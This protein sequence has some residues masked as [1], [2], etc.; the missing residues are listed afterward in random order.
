MNMTIYAAERLT[1]EGYG[2]RIRLTLPRS[3]QRAFKGKEAMDWER[4]TWHLKNKD[5]PFGL[6]L[7]LGQGLLV[8]DKDGPQE[9]PFEGIESPMVSLTSKGQ[10]EFF[11][12]DGEVKNRIKA[13]S[14]D[15]DILANGIVCIPPSEMATGRIREW[16]SGILSIDKLPIFPVELLRKEPEVIQFPHRPMANPSVEAM[17]K[18]IDRVVAVEGKG[19]DRQTFRVAIKIVSVVSDFQQALAEILIW[20]KTN[21]IP[22]WSEKELEWKIKSALKYQHRR[23]A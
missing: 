1:A 5:P 22:P 7:E 3:K 11:R 8:K 12:V 23:E 6:A 14:T 20:N 9:G 19:G 4:L 15:V 16:R 17:R 10:H 21:A 13:L 18:W 2:D